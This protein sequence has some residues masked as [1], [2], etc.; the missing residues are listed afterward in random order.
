MKKTKRYEAKRKDAG[1]GDA[2]RN[3]AAKAIR[4]T[5][6]EAAKH[7]ATA[8]KVK[9]EAGHVLVNHADVVEKIF[10]GLLCDGNVLIEG[11]P[12]TGKTL[13]VKT[14][15]GIS[16]CQ[17]SRIQFTPDLLPS[18]I[19]GI[20]SFSKQKGFFIVKGPVFANF[21]LASGINRAPPKV[22][23][24]LLEAM[25][26]RQVTIGK[27]TYP[28]PRP[29]FVMATQNPLESLGTYPL[30]DA[31]IDRFIFKLQMGHCE[32]QD[33][34]RILDQC[35]TG[36][37]GTVRRLL[38]PEAILELQEATKR[39]YINDKVKRYVV[40]IV[41]ATRNPKHYGIRHANV[42]EWG[43]S[44][45]ASISLFIA[46]KARALVEGKTFAT[47]LHV[48]RIAH[49]VLRHRITFNYEGQA[50]NISQNEFITDLLDK[51]PV[52]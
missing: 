21:L 4:I 19:V 7:S 2:K 6:A 10:L 32:K 3:D 28:L 37:C 14:L 49:D 27:E 40:S 9:E 8:R 17:F 22:Q 36:D 52:Y 12:G 16:G 39:V 44:P 50:Q 43:S 51:V 35:P 1:G 18:D 42:V 11:L 15:A 47:P 31:Q 41:D 26:E 48:K 24:A 38:S 45:R 29:F 5:A 25:Q 13:L 23:S 33:E 46:A 30:P 20:T 34:R